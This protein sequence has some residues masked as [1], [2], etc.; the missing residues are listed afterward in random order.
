MINKIEFSDEGGDDVMARL[1]SETDGFTLTV[2]TAPRDVLQEDGPVV[3]QI[4]PEDVIVVYALEYV[5]EKMEA[6]YQ[7]NHEEFGDMAHG[8]GF[9]YLINQAMRAANERFSSN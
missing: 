1:V 7:N 9:A 6:A 4:S 2:I 8:I 5:M 3:N